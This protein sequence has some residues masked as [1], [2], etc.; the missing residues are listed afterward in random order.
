M[1]LTGIFQIEDWT[2]EAVET[3]PDGIKLNTA[4]VKQSY[5]GDINGTSTVHYQL[6]YLPNGQAKFNGYE[7]LEGQIDGQDSTLV[8][9][10]KGQFENGIAS[11]QFEIVSSSPIKS[12][13]GKFGEFKSK[14]NK[15][16]QY[17]I[18]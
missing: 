15:Q 7:I 12:L 6:L 11:S 5:S 13:E 16:A 14:E 17:F 1:Q 9:Q 8:L 4:K 3:K 18:G 10:H 2:E